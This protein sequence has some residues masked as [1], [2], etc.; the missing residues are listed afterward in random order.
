MLIGG[1]GITTGANTFELKCLLLIN[2]MGLRTTALTGPTGAS[3]ATSSLAGILVGLMDA[4]LRTRQRSFP[5]PD[6]PFTRDLRSAADSFVPRSFK[7]QTFPPLMQQV[8]EE[9][10]VNVL[11]RM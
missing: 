1:Q 7:G 9:P 11:L 6:R 4:R 3:A 8:P 10:E 5:T 2:Y